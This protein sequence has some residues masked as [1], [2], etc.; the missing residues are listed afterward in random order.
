MNYCIGSDISVRPDQTRGDQRR[1]EVT[2]G[3]QRWPEVCYFEIWWLQSR[4][5]P[6][7]GLVTGESPA[8]SPPPS[9]GL[10]HGRDWRSEGGEAAGWPAG[11]VESDK[12][13]IILSYCLWLWGGEG[14]REGGWLVVT[15]V[16]ATSRV[17]VKA[18]T[19]VVSL[20]LT[21][22]QWSIPPHRASLIQTSSSF[23]KYFHNSVIR[24]DNIYI[25]ISSLLQ[26]VSWPSQFNKVTSIRLR[27][28]KIPGLQVLRVL[29][30]KTWH[31]PPALLWPSLPEQFYQLFSVII[32]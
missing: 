12:L 14:G 27:L 28:T 20:S 15:P 29:Q 5:G 18:L 3:D 7:A 31:I 10:Q 11:Q 30:I 6:A 21:G 1:P 16:L 32:V 24:P 22:P 8:A 13:W 17:V 2:R 19:A 23:I 4:A 9:A 25:A 26:R